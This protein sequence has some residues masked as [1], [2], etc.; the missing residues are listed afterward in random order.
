MR[1]RRPAWLTFEWAIPL[2]WTI[3]LICG[4]WSAV[5]VWQS[6]PSG[7]LMVAYGLL[8]VSIMAYTAVMG[9]LRRLRVGVWIGAIGV[10]WG[11]V[12]ALQ[13]G[14]ISATAAAL[15]L[16]YLLWS[17]VGTWVT[18]EMMALNPADA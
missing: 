13:V 17:P 16:P 9:K 14:P 15:L 4:V 3:I 8:E 10:V 6:R 5:L 7:G 11:A 18:W 2:I 12:L 1:L